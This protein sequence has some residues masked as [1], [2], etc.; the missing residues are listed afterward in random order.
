MIMYAQITKEII[1]FYA[2]CAR[3][4][5]DPPVKAMC[6]GPRPIFKKVFRSGRQVV[7]GAS[8]LISNMFT[9]GTAVKFRPLLCP[10]E[11]VLKL[12]INHGLLEETEGM[13]QGALEACCGCS[14]LTIVL[15]V[16]CSVGVS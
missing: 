11:E 6:S 4:P 14:S 3:V 5:K 16:V 1:L 2:F 13:I 8:F 9:R 15:F 7:I 12:K 10:S